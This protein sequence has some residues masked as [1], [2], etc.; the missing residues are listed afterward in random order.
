MNNKLYKLMNWPEIEE[1]VYSDGCDPH[2]I[3]GPHKVG[4]S[5]L[6]Q[7]FRPDAKS[8]KPHVTLARELQVDQWDKAE[9]LP[10]AFVARADHMSLMLS[11]RQEGRLVY[12]EL[13]QTPA[14]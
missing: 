14:L 11:E 3:L 5:L 1:I 12:T 10:E 6:I 9:L 7:A 2:R 13:Y 8:F 4:N